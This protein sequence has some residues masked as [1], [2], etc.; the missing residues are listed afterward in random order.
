[1]QEVVPD[2]AQ[3]TQSGDREHDISR[4]TASG[5]LHLRLL[6]RFARR[7]ANGADFGSHSSSASKSSQTSTIAVEYPRRKPVYADA[8]K[9]PITSS[10]NDKL[11]ACL[12]S[13]RT[14]G[15]SRAHALGALHSASSRSGVRHAPRGTGDRCT[16]RAPRTSESAAGAAYCRAA[17]RSERCRLPR[18][19]HRDR[20]RSRAAAALL[21]RGGG[22]RVWRV[23]WRGRCSRPRRLRCRLPLQVVFEP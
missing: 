21:L 16:K 3:C 1:M 9:M 17:F 20:G 10:A 14:R 11:T 15:A 7:L 22:F 6:M 12:L 4:A 8:P 5:A 23:V 18:S 2:A 13:R 19:R